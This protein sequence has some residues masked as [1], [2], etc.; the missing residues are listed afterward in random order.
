MKNSTTNLD[1]VHPNK[2]LCLVVED[3]LKPLLAYGTGCVGQ[4]RVTR[5]RDVIGLRVILCSRQGSRSFG[6]LQASRSIIC[7]ILD[8]V[9]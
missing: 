2:V 6:S 9:F 5:N 3:G 8:I 4:Y 1:R 7:I